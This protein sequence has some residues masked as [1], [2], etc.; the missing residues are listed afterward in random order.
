MKFLTIAF[1]LLCIPFVNAQNN[2]AIRLTTKLNNTYH[3]EQQSDSDVYLYISLLGNELKTEKKRAPLNI[4]LV[5]D[6][7]GSMSGEKLENAKKAMN[8]VIDQLSATDYLSIVAY[9]NMIEVKSPSA[10]VKNKDA[11]KQK[12]NEITARG[13]T[14]LFDGMMKGFDEVLANKKEGFVNRVLLVSDGLANIGTIAPATINEKVKLK[15]NQTGIGV[16]TFGVGADFN[17]DLMTS[18]AENGKGNYYFIDTASKIPAIFAKELDGLLSVVA[19]QTNLQ[20]NYPKNLKVEKVFGYNY[21]DTN[22]IVTVQLNDIYSNEEKEVMVHFKIIQPI[23]DKI[24]IKS[25]VDFTD[26]QLDKTDKVSAENNLTTTV[27]TILYKQN[28]DS[29]VDEMVV[30]YNTT[31]MMDKAMQEID[32]GNYIVGNDWATKADGYV[33]ANYYRT[34]TGKVQKQKITISKYKED[35]KDIDKKSAYE[36]KMLQKS[37]KQMNYDI[38]KNK[39]E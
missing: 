15:F 25:Q 37:N 24:T 32:K 39:K 10:L 18:I 27:D 28:I 3:L 16:S 6:R 8:F 9:D 22:N 11:L 21:T 35:V 36:K 12:V 7:S 4:S 38:K 26:A 17:E 5:L 33:S 1:L 34:K 29:L 20:I 23:Q 31:E 19:Q 13:S 14:N 30:V 2:Q